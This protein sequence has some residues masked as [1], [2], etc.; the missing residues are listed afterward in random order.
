MDFRPNRALGVLYA[1]LANVCFAVGNV[2]TSVYPATGSLFLWRG[3]GSGAAITVRGVRFS[4]RAFILGGL[5]TLHMLAFVGAIRV[6]PAWAPPAIL[7][8]VPAGLWFWDHVKDWR[9]DVAVLA[10]AA[11]A[12]VFSRTPGVPVSLL[13]VFLSCLAAFLLAARMRYAVRWVGRY[14]ANSAL[15][16]AFSGQALVGLVWC[17][18]TRNWAFAGGLIVVLI[19]ASVF[20]HRAMYATANSCSPTIAAALSPLSV[21]IT[22]VGVGLVGGKLPGLAQALVGLVWLVL[23]VCV[24]LMAANETKNTDRAHS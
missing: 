14:D 20:G 4:R 7:G 24:A 18:V 9:V 21:V 15:F 5:H 22:A 12:F 8:A 23:G 16:V 3:L 6:G 10:M 2:V 17:A 19:L 11:T 1:T 13:T